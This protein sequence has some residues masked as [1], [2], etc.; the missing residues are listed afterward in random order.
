MEQIPKFSVDKDDVLENSDDEDDEN[1]DYENDETDG[2]NTKNS[3]KNPKIDKVRFEHVKLGDFEFRNVKFVKKSEVDIYAHN[4]CEIVKNFHKKTFNYNDDTICSNPS[5]IFQGDAADSI[6]NLSS[7][8]NSSNE[9]T[10]FESDDEAYAEREPAVLAPAPHQPGPGAPLVLEVDQ[11]GRLVLPSSLPLI[12]L[13]NARSLY[14]KI[15]NFKRWLLEIFP[16]CAMVSETWEH[17]TRRQSLEDLLAETPYKVLSY[18]RPRGKTGGCCA[19]V[20]NQTK[21]VVEEVFEN[22]EE[23]IESVWA[24]FTPRVLDHK[25]QRIKRI[26]IGS[27]YIAPRSVMKSETIDHI[28]Q[29]IHFVRSKFNNEVNFVIGG[30]VNK[31]DYSDVI[32]SYGALKQCVT[33]GT[34]KEATLE[35]IL[36]DL[37][38]L[39]HPPTVLAPLQVDS[40]KNGKDSDH[41]IVIFAPKSDVIFKVE[42][43]K[44]I[45]KTRP[46]PESKI[47]FFAREIQNQTWEKS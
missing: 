8:H 35:I 44:K 16:D 34:R 14:N 6:S 7:S 41:K 38:N 11:T 32:D 43:T 21:F 40:E 18:R 4:Q 19:I 13:T 26:C 31:T 22:K 23:G 46:I 37:L 42:R 28:I 5:D 47:P 17:E 10:V 9:H 36:S 2:D 39:Y 20:Y 1:S 29:T 27:I 33:V 30:D 45:I 12:M 25:L 24:I 15:D 3:V